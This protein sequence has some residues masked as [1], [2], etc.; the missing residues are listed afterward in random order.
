MGKKNINVMMMNR[1]GPLFDSTF[2]AV[3]ALPPNTGGSLVVDLGYAIDAQVAIIRV[4]NS[5]YNGGGTLNI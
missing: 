2:V 1:A 3:Q 5:R 4:A